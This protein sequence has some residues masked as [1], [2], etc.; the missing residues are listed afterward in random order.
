MGRELADAVDF[1]DQ[2]RN[3]VG[4]NLALLSD[5][6]TPE[7]VRQ[8]LFDAFGPGG[9]DWLKD[10]GGPSGIPDGQLNVFEDIGLVALPG[11]V[12]FDLDLLMPMQPLTVPIDL[13]LLLPGLG[14]DID[15]LADARI[16]VSMPLKFGVSQN[17]GVFIDVSNASDITIDLEIALPTTIAVMTGD[18]RLTFKNTNGV[19]TITRDRGSWILEG[20]EV[21]QIITV[22]N[23]SK[24]NDG[25]YEVSAIDPAGLILT[26]DP[27]P[28]T[29]GTKGSVNADGPV[30]GMSI[31]TRKISL[32]GN[33]ELTFD[34]N[35][36]FPDTI[37]RDV[38]SWHEDGFRA[39]QTITIANSDLNNGSYRIDS[40]DVSGKVL[41]VRSNGGAGLQHEQRADIFVKSE[42][43]PGLDAPDRR[44]VAL[45]GQLGSREYAQIHRHPAD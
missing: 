22:E 42:A 9:L 17:D 35:A 23:S 15:A 24:G 3:K 39:G 21:G 29:A 34:D 45:H 31:E 6:L 8:A 7:L 27:T 32:T 26:L 2:I 40:I 19:G 20:F 5:V 43:S 41:T 37:T 1:V 14:L 30:T 11:E 38:G 4:D 10:T 13:D 16:G 44:L 28:A 18:P 25:D 12:T 33:P 36:S